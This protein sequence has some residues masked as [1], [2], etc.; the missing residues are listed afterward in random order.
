M[1]RNMSRMPTALHGYRQIA[2][3]VLAGGLWCTTACAGVFPLGRSTAP[4][5]PPVARTQ[6]AELRTRVL[7]DT[8]AVEVDPPLP[9]E[10]PNVEPD[11]AP[12]DSAGIARLTRLAHLW[13]TVGLHH[14]SVAT[15]GVPWDSA[16][17]IAVPRVRAATTDTALHSAY[18]RML[19]VLRDPTTR[20]VETSAVSAV[21]APAPRPVTSERTADS[22]VVLHIPP[23]A[24]FDAADSAVVRSALTSATRRVLLDLRGPAAATTLMPRYRDLHAWGEQLDAFLLNTGVAN[25]LVRGT[26]TAPSERTRRV[27]MAPATPADAMRGFRD[28][29]TVSSLRQYRGSAAASLRVALLADSTTVLSPLLLAMHDAAIASLIADGGLRDAAPVVT[30][31][32]PISS[33]VSAVVRVSEFVHDD[34]SVG[35]IADS[36]LRTMSPEAATTAALTMLRSTALPIAARPIA[37]ARAMATTPVFYDTTAYPFL[38]ARVLA[39]FRV[40][41]AMRAR[42]AHRDLYDDD[43]DQTIER[44]IPKLEAARDAAEYATAVA[45]LVASL[46]DSE[47]TL[48]GASAQLVSG[49][50]ALPFRVRVAEGRVFIRDM[51][52]DPAIA[53]APLVVGTE[54]TGVDGFP[55]TAWFSDHKRAAAASNEWSRQR[56]LVDQMPRGRVGDALVKVRDANNRERTLTIARTRAHADALPTIERP[57]G[58]PVRQLSDGVAYVDVERLT[59]ETFDREIAAAFSARAVIFDLRGTLQMDDDRLLRRL[60]QRP[61]AVIARMVQ[62]TLTAPCAAS[63][64]EAASACTDVRETTAW[65]RTIDTSSVYDGRVVALVDEHTQGAMERFAVSLEQMTSVTFVG[66]ASAGAPSWTTPLSLPG[67]LQVGIATQELRR[68]D[69]GQIQRVGLAPLIEAHPTARGVRA[70]ED[71]ILARAV[72]WVQQQEPTTRRRRDR[73]PLQ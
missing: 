45:D 39:G 68:A 59:N 15:R 24:R 32:V 3:R 9:A 4:A 18:Q 65:S 25:V 46:D 55:V 67:G 40:W 6:R 5:A 2:L 57:N 13:H 14:P 52:G 19:L 71:E 56:M 22:I 23:T 29:W 20:L 60:A 44:V 41:S 62:R 21:D 27:G 12:S 10:P 7:L 28:G 43:V 17:I 63:I 61:Q 48:R 64:R 42:H 70:S 69:G 37:H 36:T 30:V 34:G 31:P 26:I 73:A 72:Q 58:P 38:G 51:H 16:L 66:S 53:G 11:P 8:V 47:A 33:T 54:I 50:A 1:P 35:V 49:N